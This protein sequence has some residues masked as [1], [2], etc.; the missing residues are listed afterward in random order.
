MSAPDQLVHLLNSYR[1]IL[2]FPISIV[3]GPIVPIIAGFLSS[4]GIMNF[5]I[6]YAIVVVGD[7]VGDSIIYY[8]GH[9]SGRNGAPKWLRF[10][11]VTEPRVASLKEKFSEKPTKIF[12]LGKVSHGAGSTVIFA[13][14]MVQ[15]PY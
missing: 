11:G 12:S 7:L 8:F 4:T 10:L 2:L 5:Y 13:S 14:G 3:E 9:R 6:V 1:Y 15:Y